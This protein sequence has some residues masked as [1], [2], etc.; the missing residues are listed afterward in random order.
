MQAGVVAAGGGLYVRGSRSDGTGFVV[1]GMPVN[2]PLYGGRSLTVISNAIAEQSLQA[3]GY[4]AEFGGA[5]GGLI[6][7]TTRT[8]GR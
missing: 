2:N 7:T 4:S 1:N 6:A 8:G 5:N 3:G